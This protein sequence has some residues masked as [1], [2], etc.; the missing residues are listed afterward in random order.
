MRVLKES[1]IR[2]GESIDV[3]YYMLEHPRS[4][5][6]D[7]IKKYITEINPEN[8]SIRLNNYRHFINAT[9]DSFDEKFRGK[10]NLGDYVTTKNKGGQYRIVGL[11]YLDY[12]SL[13]WVTRCRR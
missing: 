5:W 1:D 8:N 6:K 4:E 7:I 3:I 11:P 2:P 13:V 9:F 10:Y 12:R